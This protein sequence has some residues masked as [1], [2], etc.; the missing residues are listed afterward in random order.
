MFSCHRAARLTLEQLERPLSNC[1]RLRRWAHLLICSLCRRHN[2]Q[3]RG[4]AFLLRCQDDTTLASVMPPS[5]RLSPE[6][7]S[8]IAAAVADRMESA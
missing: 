6:A 5:A 3:L 8:R 7:R 2:R 1:E 4:L